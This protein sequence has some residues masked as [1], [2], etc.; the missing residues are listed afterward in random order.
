MILNAFTVFHVVLS[1]IGI[2]SGV[3]AIYGLLKANAPGRWTQAFLTTT[4]ATGLTGFVF[5]FRGVTPA[6]VLGVLS[7]IALTIA[8]LSIYRYHSQGIWRRIYAITAVMALYFNVFVLVVQLFRRV[9]A[10]SAM[11]P[12]QSEPPFQIAQLAVLLL[13][14]AI[15][16][17][18][19]TSKPQRALV[20]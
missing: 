1:L 5:P 18:A 8:S 16:I 20:Q 15:G 14:A 7:L 12:T 17:R 3:V 13:F 2:G 11:A 10:L 4:A 9:P 19:A 6:Q